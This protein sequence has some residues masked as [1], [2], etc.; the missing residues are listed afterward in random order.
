M[1]MMRRFIPII[2]ATVMFFALHTKAM[3]SE[4]NYKG[5]IR[6]LTQSGN[7]VAMFPC[8]SSD[9]QKMLYTLTIKE[10][11]EEVKAIKM[12]DGVQL[13]LG[14]ISHLGRTPRQWRVRFHPD[15]FRTAWEPSLQMNSH[16]LIA[17][18]GSLK[19]NFTF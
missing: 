3:T 10:S 14:L 11:E 15:L 1:K 9:G 4:E 7:N 8:L 6:R 5:H 2:I 17:D 13:V 12:M 19:N 16:G 18:K